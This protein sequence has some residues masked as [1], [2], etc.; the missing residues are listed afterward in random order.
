ML[1]RAKLQNVEQNPFH[2]QQQK[3]KMIST[4]EKRLHTSRI[5]L[6]K[7]LTAITWHYVKTSFLKGGI[8]GLI[9]LTLVVTPHMFTLQK[10]NKVVL[11]YLFLHFL[12]SCLCA[13]KL[14]IKMYEIDEMKYF[15]TWNIQIKYLYNFCKH[16]SINVCYMK[17]EP[18]S[19]LFLL[20]TCNINDFCTT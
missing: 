6:W 8:I 4:W 10:L 1:K 14:I 15:S 16:K 20:I 17:L 3:I 2:L 12:T 11:V 5:L 19:F 13:K 7:K 9:K 18:S